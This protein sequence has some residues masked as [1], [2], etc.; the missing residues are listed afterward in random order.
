MVDA[1][2]FY[3][4]Y[5]FFLLNLVA[6]FATNSP[7]KGRVKYHKKNKRTGFVRSFICIY[8]QDAF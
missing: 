5:I 2:P 3:F 1:T 4:F 6:L 7:Y 8:G